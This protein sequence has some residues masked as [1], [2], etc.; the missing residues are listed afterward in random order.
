MKCEWW[1]DDANFHY[2]DQTE[3]VLARLTVRD[4]GS[5]EV[6]TAAGELHQFDNETEASV[7]LLDEEYRRW[8][9]LLE[10]LQEGGAY[11]DP[12]IRVPTASSNEEL[13]QQMVI[14]LTPLSSSR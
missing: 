10:D 8:E 5:A 7:W 14:S 12:R 11:V 6:L 9:S 13:R 2:S 4:D 1:Y 3:L